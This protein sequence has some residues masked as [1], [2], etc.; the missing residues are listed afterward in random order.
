MKAKLKDK[1][2]RFPL[3]QGPYKFIHPNYVHTQSSL[4]VFGQN[5]SSKY[6][7]T[8]TETKTEK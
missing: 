8:W 6:S 2:Q 5:F 4:P 1:C 3:F 7:R